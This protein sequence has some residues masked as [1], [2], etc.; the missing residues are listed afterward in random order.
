MW[1]YPQL[2]KKVPLLSDIAH[3]MSSHPLDMVTPEQI[4]V[5]CWAGAMPDPSFNSST[6]PQM[7]PEAK[8]DLHTVCQIPPSLQGMIGTSLYPWL[9][10]RFTALLSCQSLIYPTK[11]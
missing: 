4:R 5:I 3:S 1:A 10:I 8:L 11:F 9:T 6:F 2:K 7:N